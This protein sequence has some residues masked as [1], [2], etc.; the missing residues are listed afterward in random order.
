[1]ARLPCSLTPVGQP[2]PG[3]CGTAVLPSRRIRRRRQ[4]CAFRGSITPLPSS[5]CT[6]RQVDRS[7]TAQ[8]SL[9][10]AGQALPDR[11]D[12]LQGSD[13]RFQILHLIPLL[14]AWLG[15]NP[16][17]SYESGQM[18]DCLFCSIA[19]GSM[20]ALVIHEEDD[21]MAFLDIL[22]IREGHCQIIPK[23]HVEAFDD[24]EPALAG[25]IVALGQRIAKRQK[26]IYGVDRVAFLWRWCMARNV[27][28]YPVAGSR[29]SNF[30]GRWC[31]ARVS[32]S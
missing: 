30:D 17:A 29:S 8:H 20:E 5:L 6:L 3:H 1:M 11:L 25:R 7:T 15:A 23:V 9:P 21:L 16:N 14:Q 32:S 22:P 10:G 13:R 12:Y 18:E 2:V 28:R 24:L 26:E 4:H 31:M 27:D 19:T